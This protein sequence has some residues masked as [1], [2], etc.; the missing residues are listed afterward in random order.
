MKLDNIIA[1]TFN[2]I[3]LH[4]R[5]SF[6]AHSKRFYQCSVDQVLLV[7]FW[8]RVL[9]FLLANSGQHFYQMRFMPIKDIDI[10]VTKDW[11]HLC[12]IFCFDWQID[13]GGYS[14]GAINPSA[15][16]APQ[17]TVGA[18]KLTGNSKKTS[19]LN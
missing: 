13:W 9:L 8:V 10:C 14:A 5:S 7:F 16:Y 2:D 11:L 15:T 12:R 17:P 1:S 18:L 3:P 4:I 19:D 6:K